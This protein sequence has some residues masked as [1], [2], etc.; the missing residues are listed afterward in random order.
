[1]IEDIMP[2][3]RAMP[4]GASMLLDSK[5]TALVSIA[6]HGHPAIMAKEYDDAIILYVK[7]LDCFLGFTVARAY[8]SIL[9]MDTA[10]K[11]LTQVFKKD[12]IA[13]LVGW[14]LKS[15]TNRESIYDN[16][17]NNIIR[18]I[19]AGKYDLAIELMQGYV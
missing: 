1:M 2:I 5:Y 13:N 4:K 19:E 14:M 8:N 12:E 10:S 17:K 9:V 18:L 6:K 3:L 7:G 15:I 16:E 11:E